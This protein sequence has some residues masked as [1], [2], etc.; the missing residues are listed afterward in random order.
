MSW[1]PGIYEFEKKGKA[2][3]YA[4]TV[5]KIA[6]KKKIR[7]RNL[8][9][10]Q[11]CIKV[12]AKQEQACQDRQAIPRTPRQASWRCHHISLLIPLFLRL[13]CSIH[14]VYHTPCSPA[15]DPFISL[16]TTH[17][18]QYARQDQIIPACPIS[19][20]YISE[21]EGSRHRD[22]GDTP[23]ACGSF[24]LVPWL[25]ILHARAVGRSPHQVSSGDGSSREH[26][27][28]LVGCSMVSVEINRP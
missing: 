15:V 13:S 25:L 12:D 21:P 27:C 5:G 14:I 23:G 24:I 19:T 16:L 20:A 6:N 26:S 7:R 22:L 18:T 2:T 4:P 11:A 28:R 10:I 1:R 3:I 17:E 9:S 8:L